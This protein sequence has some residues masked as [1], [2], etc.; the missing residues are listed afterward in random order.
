M[1]TPGSIPCYSTL[2]LVKLEV[3]VLLTV[4]DEAMQ[5]VPVLGKVD[6]YCLLWCVCVSERERERE[7]ERKRVSTR[8]I[9]RYLRN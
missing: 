2:Y 5:L 1:I 3:P 7:R 4:V 6:A 8:L 9:S